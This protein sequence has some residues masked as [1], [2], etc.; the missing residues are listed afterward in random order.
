[1]RVA[2]SE[3]TGSITRDGLSKLRK[4]IGQDCFCLWLD[5]LEP[6][7][8]FIEENLINNVCLVNYFVTLLTIRSYRTGPCSFLPSQT[9]IKIA[10]LH[11]VMV[12][13]KNCNKILPIEDNFLVEERSDDC[14]IVRNRDSL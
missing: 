13:T 7:K 8:I 10:A 11:N 1:M 14:K 9:K 3:Y 2:P 12:P 6:N 4:Q 5:D